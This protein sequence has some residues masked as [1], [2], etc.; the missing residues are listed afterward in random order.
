[1]PEKTSEALNNRLSLEE[2]KYGLQYR[3]HV[4]PRLLRTSK[5]YFLR[6]TVRFIA[7]NTNEDEENVE[8]LLEPEPESA[9]EASNPTLGQ[10]LDVGF[11]TKSPVDPLLPFH[12]RTSSQTLHRSDPILSQDLGDIIEYHTQPPFLPP[13][14]DVLSTTPSNPDVTSDAPLRPYS[15]PSFERSDSATLIRGSVDWP[16]ISPGHKYSSPSLSQKRSP[17]DVSHISPFSNS[18]FSPNSS[19]SLSWPV[20]DPLEARLFH[21]YIV[22]CSDWVDICDS[23]RHFTREVPKRAAHFPVILNAILGLASRHLWLIGKLDEDRSQPYVDQCL[24][25]LIV[26]LE[27][28]LA[29]WDENFLVAVI[30]LRLHEEIGED[31]EQCHHF[32]TARI[33]NSISSF[34]SDGGLRESASWVSLRQHIYVSLTKQQPFNLS[35]DNYKHSSVFRDYDDEAWT[36]RIVYQFALILQHVFEDAEQANTLSREKWTELNADTDEWCRT[37]AWSFAPL[38]ADPKAGDS[39]D[40]TWPVLP[41]PQ[42]VVAIGLQYYHLCKIL[43][44]IYSPNASLVGLAGVRARKSTDAAIRKHIRIVIGYGVSNSHCS[45]VMFQGSHILS[46]CG[47]YIVDKAEQQACVEYLTSLQSMIGWRTDKVL[48]EVREQWEN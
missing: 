4:G 26:A 1:M 19:L 30:L 15:D 44:T 35:L 6:M 20:K 11:E 46:A 5:A 27:D 37:K 38:Y 40:G 34:A 36:N 48:A 9:S 25:S 3:L 43:L 16:M 23:R 8:D 21:H 28:P 42:G 45:N 10:T 41:T 18:A 22:A 17:N 31:D 33:L 12:E 29:H 32:G 14:A 13:I 7:P 2:A 47:A 39:F 24:Q